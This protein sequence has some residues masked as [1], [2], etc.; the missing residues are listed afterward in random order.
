MKFKM[1]KNEKG[2]VTEVEQ[3]KDLKYWKENAEEDYLKVPISVLKY[4]SK[5]ETEL[6][7][8]YSEEEVLKVCHD[9]R[10]NFE[11]YRNI[12]VLPEVFFSWFEQIKKK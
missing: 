11:L 3:L 7:T 5:L 6:K 4:I 1:I 12:Q 10:N 8:V 2:Q 9:Y